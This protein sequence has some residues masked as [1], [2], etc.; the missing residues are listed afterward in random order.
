[1]AWGLTNDM[2][3][4][5]MDGYDYVLDDAAPFVEE[6]PG[7]HYEETNSIGPSGWPTILEAYEEILGRRPGP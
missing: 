5:L 3:G 1:M 2:L 7:D 4:Y 6:A